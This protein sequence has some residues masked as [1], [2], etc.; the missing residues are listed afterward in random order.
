MEHHFWSVLPLRYTTYGESFATAS[1]AQ[2]VSSRLK[3]SR[4]SLSLMQQTMLPWQQTH[5][6]KVSFKISGEFQSRLMSIF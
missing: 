5:R 3:V 6:K 1:K 4:W 2:R